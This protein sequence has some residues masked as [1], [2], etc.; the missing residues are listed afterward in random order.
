M[1]HRKW[2]ERKYRFLVSWTRG[3]DRWVNGLFLHRD[4]RTEREFD[5]CR[6]LASFC[7]NSFILQVK[8]K[9]NVLVLFISRYRNTFCSM[10]KTM[11][12]LFHKC[13]K[14]DAFYTCVDITATMA[15][16]KKS[17][18]ERFL[19]QVFIFRWN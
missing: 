18:K 13:V 16:G 12:R 14:A 5:L 6:F 1:S 8:F 9:V 15:K 2:E 17:I 19:L 4:N 3:T 11:S 7:M 10:N